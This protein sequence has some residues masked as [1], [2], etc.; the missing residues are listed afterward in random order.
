MNR[1]RRQSPRFQVSQQPVVRRRACPQLGTRCVVSPIVSLPAPHTLPASAD[2][3]TESESIPPLHTFLL[4]VDLLFL[5]SRR[6]KLFHPSLRT[7]LDKVQKEVT[8]RDSRDLS[9]TVSRLWE[10]GFLN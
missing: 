9:D 10:C 4:V 6:P 3:P 7:A 5:H 8:L 1:P 2:R